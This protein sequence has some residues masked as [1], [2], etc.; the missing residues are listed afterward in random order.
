MAGP[1]RKHLVQQD[2]N[3]S[4]CL[5]KLV[6]WYPLT[7][8]RGNQK[9]SSCR[10]E[11]AYSKIPTVAVSR[12]LHPQTQGVTASHHCIPV[13]FIIK[14]FPGSFKC[15]VAAFK[16]HPVAL[17]RSS[18]PPLLFLSAQ[19]LWLSFCKNIP[20]PVLESET[21]SQPY[22]QT[23]HTGS[24]YSICDEEADSFPEHLRVTLHGD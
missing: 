12:L 20:P 21:L 3:N 1:V 17:F 19:Q 9:D 22:T 4:W 2:H 6:T 11:K 18:T 10:A 23:Q 24:N 8:S 16:C 15:C 7:N 14:G 13:I 5:Q